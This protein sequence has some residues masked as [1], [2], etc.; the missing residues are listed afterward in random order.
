MTDLRTFQI[1]LFILGTLRQDSTMTGRTWWCC[2]CAEFLGR[3]FQFQ[4]STRS[5]RQRREKRIGQ[6]PPAIPKAREKRVRRNHGPLIPHAR[7]LLILV[8]PCLMSENPV[9]N[10]GNQSSYGNWTRGENNQDLGVN[11]LAEQPEHRRRCV[12]KIA[13][14]GRCATLTRRATCSRRRLY[15]L[16]ENNY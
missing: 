13:T 5:K 8:K 2:S 1:G 15:N 3:R 12:W 9:T 4:R 6:R 10:Q 11:P 16:C 7:Q 14:E